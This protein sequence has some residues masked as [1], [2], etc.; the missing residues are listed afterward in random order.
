MTGR[1][2]TASFSLFWEGTGVEETTAADASLMAAGS[3]ETP[4]GRVGAA[5]GSVGATGMTVV[6][7]VAT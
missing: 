2:T 3:V 4:T 7:A 1:A 6:P 5:T